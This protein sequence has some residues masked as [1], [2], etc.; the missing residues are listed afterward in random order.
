MTTLYREC[1]P[2]LRYIIIFP[3]Y[4]VHE[5]SYCSMR[6]IAKHMHINFFRN[7]RLISNNN[8]IRFSC[9]GSCVVANRQLASR[10][11]AVD[12]KNHW[13][14]GM[15]TA[16]IIITVG[17]QTIMHGNIIF[18]LLSTIKFYWPIQTWF[19]IDVYFATANKLSNWY[20]KEV[21]VRLQKGS[22]VHVAIC[23][24]KVCR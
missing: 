16:C 2:W 12:E 15:V 13:L 5:K 4:Y 17:A 10:K 23:F 3:K 1:C 11:W 22:E 7:E 24:D 21:R 18:G 9:I 6:V 8:I 19:G 14:G 20:W